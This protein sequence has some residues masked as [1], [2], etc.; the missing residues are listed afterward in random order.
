MAVD[1]AALDAAIATF[2]EKVQDNMRRWLAG[3][4]PLAPDRDTL[5]RV[6]TDGD[7]AALAN[8]F[9]ADLPFGTGGRRGS[10]LYGPGGMNET[11]VAA[12]VQGF[13]NHLGASEGSIVLAN[14]SR[15]FSDFEGNFTYLGDSHPLL[16][17]SSRDFA[18][19]AAEIVAGNGLTV[20][21]SDPDNPRA[22]L[23]TPELSFAVPHLGALGGVNLSA[24]HN[25]P[26]H[27]GIKVFMAAGEQPIPPLDQAMIDTM[28]SAVDIKRMDFN[29][30]R[31]AGLIQVIPAATDAAYMAQY[32]ALFRDCA[33]AP[34]GVPVVF[35]PLGGCA[36]RTAFALLE[37]L[38][39]DVHMPADQVNDGSFSSI[40]LR[41]PNPE[42]PVATVPAQAFANK[43][44][45][46]IVLSCDPD[47]DRVGADIR[48]ADG[49]WTRFDGNQLATIIAYFLALDPQGP[50]R[51]G[52]LI[53][54]LVTTRA[55]GK[56]AE[57]SGNQCV[58]NLLVGFKYIADVIK[59]LAAEGRYGDVTGSADD[60][61]V[62]TEESHGFTLLPTVLDKDGAPPVMLLAALHGR[63]VAEGRTLLDYYVDLLR[64]IGAH[65]CGGRSIV[66]KGANGNER[67]DSIMATLRQAP[68]SELGGEPVTSMADYWN[69]SD[70]GPIVSDT[71]H[72]SRNVISFETPAFTVVVRPSGT[73]PKLKLYVLIAGGEVGDGDAAEIVAALKATTARASASVYRSLLS[74]LGVEVSDAAL[75]LPDIV[76]LDARVGFDTELV[77]ALRDALGNGLP[78]SDA[79]EAVIRKHGANLTPGS[80]PVPAV[81]EALAA[82]SHESD[83]EGL[84]PL[85]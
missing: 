21:M 35:T 68:P 27:N 23:T 20:Y 41:A 57:L 85:L 43:H 65:D 45:A 28:S 1:S 63:M 78:S 18:R 58:D 56:I 5:T 79:L 81:G 61:I 71:D 74:T 75:A 46:A 13:I 48:L 15:L 84:V 4:V 40:P 50:Q 60:L 32:E 37:R 54:T 10:V 49:T 76:D 2:P 24:S 19:L 70:F 59:S 36:D 44:G 80:D 73:E 83:F 6:I 69:E 38:G 64:H 11:T 9:G 22:T 82:L 14:D 7:P 29:K 53:E 66:L 3:D 16:G 52:V 33:L 34:A 30:A 17:K 55:I 25:P 12:T 42:I 77:P 39:F 31:A 47:G 51:K 26:D 72:S 67:R 62:A 8:A